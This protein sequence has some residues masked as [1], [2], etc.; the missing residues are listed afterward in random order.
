VYHEIFWRADETLERFRTE[1][2][3]QIAHQN[4]IW[5]FGYASIG[6]S[7]ILRPSR[8]SRSIVPVNSPEDE[9]SPVR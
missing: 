6:Y 7:V 3:S 8:R 2:L 5:I 1:N 4:E 9:L